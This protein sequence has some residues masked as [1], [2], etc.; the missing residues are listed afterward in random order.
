M[1]DE[2]EW[3]RSRKVRAILYKHRGELTNHEWFLRPRL[4][5]GMLTA[6]ASAAELH[7][8]HHKDEK[9][10]W[11][12]PPKIWEGTNEDSHFDLTN[13]SYKSRAYGTGYKAVKCI[14][15]SFRRDELLKV[16]DIDASD[17]EPTNLLDA[18]EWVS[19]NNDV[20][21]HLIRECNSAAWWNYPEAIA[22]VMSRD[23]AGVARTRGWLSYMA[24]NGRRLTQGP[25]EAFLGT[26]QAHEARSD[27]QVALVAEGQ[28]LV[29]CQGRD[30]SGALV[31]IPA[32]EWNGCKVHFRD[33]TTVLAPAHDVRFARY[34]DLLFSSD[35]L[36]AAYPSEASR[37]IVEAEVA[38]KSPEKF[39]AKTMPVKWKG[40]DKETYKE[41]AD[42]AAQM[43]SD[44]EA[45]NLGQAT[46]LIVKAG[47]ILI[48]KDEE[49]TEKYIYKLAYQLY[50]ALKA[51][52]S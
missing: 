11:I 40:T 8:R 33:E 44:G 45:S 51:P 1:S 4:R 37:M 35:D 30:S 26:T 31:S 5:S 24:E 41:Y 36:R 34:C 9:F 38:E 29:R 48:F 7:S 18:D 47:D 2:I 13:D 12:M 6:K 32:G 52:T 50:G 43:V 16:A 20:T 49:Y 15:L 3:V 25:L 27:L 14:G 22:W 46:K 23:I 19:A 42:K 28:G 10:D 17:L 21:S 39:V